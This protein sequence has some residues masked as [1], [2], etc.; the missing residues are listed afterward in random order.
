MSR[1][2]NSVMYPMYTDVDT[3]IVSFS[4]ILL[5]V[6]LKIA[7]TYPRLSHSVTC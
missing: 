1:L 6:C 2:T 5:A 3:N 7:N 4:N